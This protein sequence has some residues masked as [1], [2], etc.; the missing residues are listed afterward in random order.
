MNKIEKYK[1]EFEPKHLPLEIA[2]FGNFIHGANKDQ[3]QIRG[4]YSNPPPSQS[5]QYPPQQFG[6]PMMAGGRGSMP[7]NG[8]PQ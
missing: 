2:K 8:Q 3:Q 6:N 4:K 7:Q 1:N 5:Q